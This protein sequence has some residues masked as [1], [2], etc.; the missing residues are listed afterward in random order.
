MV[1]EVRHDTLIREVEAIPEVWPVVE[2]EEHIIKRKESLTEGIS[3]IEVEAPLIAEKVKPGQFVIF[4]T[5]EKGERIPFTVYEKDVVK[6]T[7]TVIFQKVGKSTIELDELKQGEK[8]HDVIGPLGNATP[9]KKYGTVVCVGGGVGVAELYP[10]IAAL[11]SAGNRVVV[12]MGFKTKDLVICEDKINQYANEL[13]I[14]TDDGSY[15]KGIW[16]GKGFVTKALQEMIDYPLQMSPYS[17]VNI[18]I[19]FAVGPLVMM[20]NVC[21]VTRPFGIKT[22]VSLNPVMLDGTGMCGSCRVRV[23][24]EMKFACVDGPEFDGHKVDFLE[25]MQRQEMFNTKEQES[26]DHY[27]MGCAH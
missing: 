13:Y 1:D 21:D 6:G 9:I 23:D 11:K 8:V 16:G 5:H 2:H 18:D 7:I 3:M 22:V 14:T 26:L 15:G 25:L 19:V 27:K 12:V 24:G 20:K 4:R 10:I 17:G